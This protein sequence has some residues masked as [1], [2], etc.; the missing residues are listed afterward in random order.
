VDRVLAV[1][2][3][4]FVATVPA[5]LIFGHGGRD[6]AKVLSIT[7]R[8]FSTRRI[9]TVV[10]KEANAGDRRETPLA[11]QRIVVVAVVG[12]YC[13]AAG[14]EQRVVAGNL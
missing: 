8:L 2:I 11:P 13:S 1:I 5:I 14:K 4:V 10:V 12:G 6:A 7:T 9:G 3:V